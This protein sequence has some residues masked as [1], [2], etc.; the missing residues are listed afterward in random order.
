L[1]ALNDAV[2]QGGNIDAG[3][4]LTTKQEK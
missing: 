3:V 2:G 1:V 4:A